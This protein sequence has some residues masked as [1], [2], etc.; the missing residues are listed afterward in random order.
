M[1]PHNTFCP[2]DACPAR[3]QPHQ[4]NIHVHSQK[5]HRYRCSV[6][7]KTFAA[8]TGTPLYRLH[9]E[10]QWYLWVITLLAFGCPP[11]AIVRAFGLDARTV[12]RWQQAAGTHAKHLQQTLVET[13][14]AHGQVQVD[15]LHIRT[16]GGVVWVASAIAVASRLW[17]GAVVQSA[18][19]QALAVGILQRVRRCVQPETFWLCVDGWAPYVTAARQIFRHAVPRGGQRGRCQLRPWPGLVLVQVV[20]HAAHHHLVGIVRRLALGEWTLAHRWF[21]QTQGHGVFSTAWIERL[22]ATFRSRLHAWVRRG[23]ARLRSPQAVQAATYLMGTVYNFCTPHRTLS[24]QRPTTP[25]MA[26]GITTD[27]W[28]VERVLTTPATIARW[29]PPPHRG[30]K[31]RAELRCLA[32]WRPERL[33]PTDREKVRLHG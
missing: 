23:R 2:N 18:R 12:R 7:G 24:G 30:H 5:D 27:I 15:E 17:L 25:A 22:N 26:A 33:S 8:T 1:T 16:Q 4:G 21:L 14:R 29:D 28:S 32:R 31:S 6:C 19:D 11:I 3:G 13:P 10:R 20:K 9:G